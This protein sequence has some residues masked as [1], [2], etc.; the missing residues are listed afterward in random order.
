MGVYLII[1]RV[2]ISEILCSKHNKPVIFICTLEKCAQN[3][4]ICEQ[5]KTSEAQHISTHVNFICPYKQFFSYQS[6]K[7]ISEYLP[8]LEG[9]LTACEN[10]LATYRHTSTQ[11]L[12]AINEDF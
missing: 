5:C 2:M 1:I 7:S 6:N 9:G 8:K 3:Y 4:L 11:Q 12:K 10:D